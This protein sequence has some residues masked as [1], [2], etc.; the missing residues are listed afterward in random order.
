MLHA[1]CTDAG[2]PTV[3]LWAAVP[4]YVP[5]ATSPKAALALVERAAD[6]L[7]VHVV[8]TDLEIASAGYERQISA[9][10]AEDE[11]TAAFVAQLEEHYDDDE[12][13]EDEP[14][15]EALV[16]EVERFLRNQTD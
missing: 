5:G 1:A 16:E 2:I 12:D 9:L 13:D 10:V 15:A 6:L 11:D 14:D 8:T 3:S 4:S 7:G